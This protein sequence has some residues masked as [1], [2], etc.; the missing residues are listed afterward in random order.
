MWSDVIISAVCTDMGFFSSN[1]CTYI[2][3][4]VCVLFVCLGSDTHRSICL[5][6]EHLMVSVCLFSLRLCIS[7]FSKHLCVCLYHCW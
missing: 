2:H 3:V 7:V 4:S 1:P 5:I 6:N